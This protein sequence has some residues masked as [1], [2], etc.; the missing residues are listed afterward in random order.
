MGPLRQEIQDHGVLVSYVQI[1]GPVPPPGQ[2][3]RPQC[4]VVGMVVALELGAVPEA[5]T[6]LE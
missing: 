2:S 1:Q 4:M 3:P 5:G 6:E